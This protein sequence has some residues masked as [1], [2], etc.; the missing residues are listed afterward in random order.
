MDSGIEK[1]LGDTVTITRVG[2]IVGRVHPAASP[3]GVVA[4]IGDLHGN[5]SV[6]RNIFAI[7]AQLAENPSF[8]LL[9][10]EGA[11]GPILISELR[12][13][14]DQKFKAK[15]GGRLLRHSMLTGPQYFDLLHAE[16]E[17]IMW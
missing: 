11:E 7:L 3:R 4:L 10:L 1:L 15:V 8:K 14:S 9:C 5:L 13:I 16:M 12:K 17:L 6:Q 2:S